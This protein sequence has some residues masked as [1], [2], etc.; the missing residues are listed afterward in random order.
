MHGTYGIDVE[1]PRGT[2]VQQILHCSRE[3][4]GE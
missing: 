4:A 3:D 1:I 2:P